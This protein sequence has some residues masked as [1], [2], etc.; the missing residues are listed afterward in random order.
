ML[1]TVLHRWRCL[2]TGGHVRSFT[3]SIPCA[4]VSTR[5]QRY[6]QS[7]TLEGLVNEA[8]QASTGSSDNY[9]SLSKLICTVGPSTHSPSHIQNLVDI[10]MSVMRINCSKSTIEETKERVEWLRACQGLQ[11]G[12]IQPTPTR[13]LN[14]RSIMFD[15]T[16]EEHLQWAID[17]GVDFVS[18][19]AT[20]VGKVRSDLSRMIEPIKPLSSIPKLIAKI[21]S[22]DA[23]TNFDEILQVSDGI[24]IERKLL[25]QDIPLGV[26]RAQKKIVQK[27]NSAGKPVII[28]SQML[29][30]MI[31]HPTP[32]R[33]EVSDIVNAVCK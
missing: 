9:R 19:N 14:L 21:Q 1:R 13:P 32:T 29:D 18:F 10:G 31:D 7:S 5:H 33:A 4:K 27:C 12:D 6:E 30:T 26:V 25:A 3:T 28:A 15:T 23:L 11:G 2:K 17:M 24:L 22:A 20:H 16:D 8:S